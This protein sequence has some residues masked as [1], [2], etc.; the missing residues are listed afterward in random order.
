MH[1]LDKIVPIDLC[2]YGMM[3]SEDT[4]GDLRDAQDM[5]STPK[6]ILLDLNLFKAFIKKKCS[7]GLVFMA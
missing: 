4:I 6:M 1:F 7:Y 2:S 5:L 3:S